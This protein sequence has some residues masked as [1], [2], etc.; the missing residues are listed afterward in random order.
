MGSRKYRP[1]F[2]VIIYCIFMYLSGMIFEVFVVWM[3]KKG[4]YKD[5]ITLFI[6]EEGVGGLAYSILESLIGIQKFL[7]SYEN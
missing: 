2:N 6:I 5:C 3:H 1:E 4:F 7:S